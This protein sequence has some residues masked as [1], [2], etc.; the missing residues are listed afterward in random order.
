M[1]KQLLIF[2]LFIFLATGHAYA[3][4]FTI[5]THDNF[6]TVATLSDRWRVMTEKELEEL[7]QSITSAGHTKS[8]KLLTAFQ[9]I[10]P[11]DPKS[12]PYIIIFMQEGA[13]IEM[14]QIQKMYSWFDNNKKLTSSVLKNS[15]ITPLNIKDIEFSQEVPSIFFQSVQEINNQKYSCVGG[16]TFLHSGYLNI[17][18]YAEHSIFPQYEDDFLSIT[19]HLSIPTSLQYYRPSSAS[20][21]KPQK[22][23]SQWL[24]S[25]FKRLAGVMII[26]IVYGITF[27]KKERL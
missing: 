25:N 12:P 16:I 20:P 11:P 4:V 24:R 14:D 15:A 27:L 5:P 19:K 7:S 8:E 13:R 23:F 2:L 3:S 21:Q 1:N 10:A 22:T 9:V 26:L 17:V 18:G 6:P